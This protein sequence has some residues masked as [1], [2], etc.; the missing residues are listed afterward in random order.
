MGRESPWYSRCGIE[1]GCGIGARRPASVGAETAESGPGPSPI[2][3]HSEEL[4]MW[5]LMP[6]HSPATF[7]KKP[8]CS[9]NL[10]DRSSVSQWKLLSQVQK[11]NCLQFIHQMISF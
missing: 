9:R 7:I 3:Q 10:G 11:S 1:F 2:K 5:R 4:S 8:G 6:R